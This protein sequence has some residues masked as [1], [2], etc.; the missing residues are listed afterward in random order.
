MCF[1]IV[2]NWNLRVRVGQPYPKKVMYNLCQMC[3]FLETFYV[4]CIC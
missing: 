1:H 4:I 3:K 2:T